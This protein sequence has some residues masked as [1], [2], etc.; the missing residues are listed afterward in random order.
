MVTTPKGYKLVKTLNDAWGAGIIDECGIEFTE[1]NINNYMFIRETPH[2]SD[3]P[4][5]FAKDNYAG[6]NKMRFAFWPAPSDR[7]YFIKLKFFPAKL[8]EFWQDVCNYYIF[9]KIPDFT[10]KEYISYWNF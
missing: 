3:H 1:R 8:P 9:E 10:P 5:Y 6:L 4:L 7:D 2:G